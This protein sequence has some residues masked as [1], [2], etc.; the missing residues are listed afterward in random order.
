MSP[1]PHYLVLSGPNLN[2]LG[3]RE[4]KV[5]GLTTLEEIHA[6]MRELARLLRATVTCQQ[7]NGEGD[8]LDALHGAR[9]TAQGVVLNPGAYAHYSLAL[10]DAVAAIGLPVVEVHLTNVHARESFRHRLVVA[11][12]ALG[13]VAG[14][15]PVGYELALVALHAHVTGEVPWHPLATQGKPPSGP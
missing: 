5:Y 3:T 4:P 15:G 11:P 9:D 2:L 13:V 1:R 10:R 12:K 14:L 7:A 6:R 8:L